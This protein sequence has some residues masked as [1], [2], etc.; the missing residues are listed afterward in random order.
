MSDIKT[1]DLSG[2]DELTIDRWWNELNCFRW[3][4]DFPE[5]APPGWD[6]WTRMVYEDG[7][8]PYCPAIRRFASAGD[9]FD[10]LNE[11]FPELKG[12]RTQLEA[13]AP[14]APTIRRSLDLRAALARERAAR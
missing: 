3:P 6:D 7:P 2:Y 9:W 13:A 1:L 5:P 8:L 10:A 14:N 12:Y 11:T 4:D